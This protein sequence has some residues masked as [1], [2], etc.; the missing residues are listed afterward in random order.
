MVGTEEGEARGSVGGIG[1]GRDDATPTHAAGGAGRAHAPRPPGGLHTA[2]RRG[3]HR[4]YGQLR[5]GGARPVLR[6]LAPAAYQPPLSRAVTNLC[7]SRVGL[8]STSKH[9]TDWATSGRSLLCIPRAL[10]GYPGVD[11]YNGPQC[12]PAAVCRTPAIVGKCHPMKKSVAV[13]RLDIALRDASRR[14]SWRR[15]WRCWP[16]AC[17]R[18]RHCERCCRRHQRRSRGPAAPPGGCLPRSRHPARATACASYLQYAYS[19]RSLL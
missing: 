12:A 16:T 10:Q 17:S 1:A 5:G 18:L 8:D 19:R 14:R 3:W 2:R 9:R 11:I 15:R 6:P 7:R 13:G 4:F